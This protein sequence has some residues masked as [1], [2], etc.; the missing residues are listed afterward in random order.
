M[1]PIVFVRRLASLSSEHWGTSSLKNI[2]EHFE[3]TSE[4]TRREMDFKAGKLPE[5]ILDSAYLSY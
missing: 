1:P 4:I 3:Q 2:F 5:P